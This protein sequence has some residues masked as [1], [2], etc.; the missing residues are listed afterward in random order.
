MAAA[1]P[2]VQE[3]IPCLIYRNLQVYAYKSSASSCYDVYINQ[4]MM[5]II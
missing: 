3:K 5:I 2:V 1:R 4:F